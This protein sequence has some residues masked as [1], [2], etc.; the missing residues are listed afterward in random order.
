MGDSYPSLRPGRRRARIN[1]R[2]T[3]RSFPGAWRG[4]TSRALGQPPGAEIENAFSGREEPLLGPAQCL[5][6]PGA[7][8]EVEVSGKWLEPCPE[9]LLEAVD[10]IALVLRVRGMTG[11]R[12]AEVVVGAAHAD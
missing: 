4:L 3:A 8:N 7:Q 10:S 1:G 6:T 2:M 11:G 9:A 5:I 12:A